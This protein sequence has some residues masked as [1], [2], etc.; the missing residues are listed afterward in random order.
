MV[1]VIVLLSCYFAEREQEKHAFH[2]CFLCFISQGSS[3][4]KG[5]NMGVSSLLIFSPGT[6]QHAKGSSREWDLGSVRKHNFQMKRGKKAT[7]LSYQFFLSL[8]LPCALRVEFL[9]TLSLM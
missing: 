7:L 3:G 2:S 1:A 6:E 5:G 9:S 4:G 8:S